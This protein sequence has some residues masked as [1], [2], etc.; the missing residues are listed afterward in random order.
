[1][2][3]LLSRLAKLSP[4]ERSLLR[5][6]LRQSA[7]TSSAGAGAR[8]CE[9]PLSFAQ[10]RLWFLH[11][12]APEDSSYNIPAAFR[13]VG[14]LD[15]DVFR[16][17][18]RE[19]VRRHEILRTRFVY[20]DGAAFQEVLP[21]LEIA[22]PC[23]DLSGLREERREE[24]AR[25]RV[26]EQAR[27]PFDLGKAPLLRA[28]LLD[29]G[30]RRESQEREYVVAITLHHIV[31]DGWSTDILIREFKE[32]YEAFAAGGASPLPALELQYGDYSVWQREWLQGEVL[33][34]QLAYW[35]EALSGAPATLELMTDH[36]RP[37]TQDPRGAVH[38]FLVPAG[39][40][41]KLRDL[42]RRCGA[43]L[44]MTLLAA[45]DALLFRHSGQ[46]D[47]CVGT[48]VANRRRVELEGLIGFFVNTLV[49]RADLS[50][51]PSFVELL[52]R[53]RA[54]ALGAQANQDLP[55][56]RLVEELQPERDMSRSPLFQTMFILQNA[57]LRALGL[58]GLRIDAFAMASGTAK[59]DLTLQASEGED[60][61]F[62]SLEY[63]TTLFDALTIERMARRFQLLLE[64]IATSPERRLSE[65]PL[66]PPEERRQ[67]LFDWNPA[68]TYAEN[69]CLHELFEEQAARSPG[70]VAV[71]FEDTQLSYG[72][73]NAKANRLAHYLRR[74]G[75]GP[76][77][78]VGLCVERSL[79]MVIGLLG[80]LKA[81]APICRL[82]RATRA[83]GSLI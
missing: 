23:V 71:V 27:E 72:E 13:L 33:E 68:R 43:T 74:R 21:D 28:L 6:R 83:S 70:A 30:R 79:E 46:T 35:R 34:R 16:D 50:G 60:G 37:A 49:M 45:F 7:G 56:E 24:E 10:Q 66:L 9:F 15:L 82:I 3:E 52:R 69:R 29:M 26:E 64:G 77:V 53:V 47:V 38:D 51:D 40:T 54:Q 76:E 12:I 61:L 58:S 42:G 1:M 36:P 5:N 31:S 48:P 80:V 67:I 4:H 14:D 19:I 65:L 17:C 39:V 59:F 32:L 63:A 81:G 44:F 20:R 73:L 57:P 2:N 25:R 41:A 62:F 8:P 18:L 78:I 22:A 11:Q 75:V 55:F